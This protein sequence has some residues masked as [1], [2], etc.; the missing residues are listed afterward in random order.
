MTDIENQTSDLRASAYG[1]DDACD[2]GC[3]M[4]LPLTTNYVHQIVD[5]ITGIV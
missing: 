5:S 3:K 4:K 1:M 2:K